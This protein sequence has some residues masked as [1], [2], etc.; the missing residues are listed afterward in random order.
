[1][2]GGPDDLSELVGVQLIGVRRTAT[3]AQALV[4]TEEACLLGGD[5]LV[6]AP[7]LEEIAIHIGARAPRRTPD[8]GAG[9]HRG[10]G[11]REP[12]SSMSTGAIA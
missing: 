11:R 8:P 4:R 2:R 1:V 5:V 9:R 10:A 12:D 3:G 7:T 6:E